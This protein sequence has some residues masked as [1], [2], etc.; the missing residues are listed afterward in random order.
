MSDRRATTRHLPE[1]PR[2][3]GRVTIKPSVAPGALVPVARTHTHLHARADRVARPVCYS[4]TTR[5]LLA[6][7][8]PRGPTRPPHAPSSCPRPWRTLPGEPAP[9]RRPSTATAAAQAAR[10]RPRRVVQR[11]HDG[12][13]GLSVARAA[14]HE[15]REEADAGRSGGVRTT[16]EKVSGVSGTSCAHFLVLLSVRGCIRAH[17]NVS[18]GQEQRATPEGGGASDAPRECTARRAGQH[19]AFERVDPPRR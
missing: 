3:S 18:H 7:R 17:N 2:G 5:V 11:L 9:P 15:Q 16:S 10:R 12:E 19:P 8:T 6:Q 14:R 1:P 13:E 4:C